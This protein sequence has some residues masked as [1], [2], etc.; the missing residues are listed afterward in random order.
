MAII[1]GQSRVAD[2]LKQRSVG[3]RM[4]VEL[5]GIDYSAR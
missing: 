5:S 1:I 3:N 2:W 4:L